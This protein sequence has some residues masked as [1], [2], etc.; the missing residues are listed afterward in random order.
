[1]R[2]FKRTNEYICNL[3]GQKSFVKRNCI[4]LVKVVIFPKNEKPEID[5][6]PEKV[7]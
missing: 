6:L 4:F 5:V 1:M 3:F 7:I 2:V